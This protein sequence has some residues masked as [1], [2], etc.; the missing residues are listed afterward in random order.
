MKILAIDIGAGTQDILLHNTKETI[1]NSIKIVAP[2]PTKNYATQ[3][4]TINK[5][6]YINGNIMGGGPISKALTTHIQKG[7]EVIMEKHPA[8]TIK[9]DLQKVQNKGIK[10]QDPPAPE[11]YPKHHKITLHDVN[12]PHILQSI[13]TITQNTTSAE[14]DKIAIAQQDHGYQNG[15]SDRNFRFQKIQEKLQKPLKPEQFA[16]TN[17]IPPYYTRLTDT[18]KQLQNYNPL[19]MDSKFAAITGATQDPT[20]KK[21]KNYIIMDIGNGHTMTATIHKGKIYGLYEHHTHNLTP[22]KIEKYNQELANATLKHETIYNDHG[23]GAHCIKP[24]PEIEKI[25]ATGPQRHILENTTLNYHHAAPAG[26]VMMTGPVGLIHAIK[27]Q[28]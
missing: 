7:H 27:T 15:L 1:E 16:H 26:D 5:P 6:L 3:I 11:K 25:I 28:C 20:A 17:N 19:L 13:K 18:Y 14:F 4:Q 10:I 21:L 12:L 8:H 2:S 22:T 9:D 23:H 24:I